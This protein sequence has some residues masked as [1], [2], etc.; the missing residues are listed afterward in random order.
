MPVETR[1]EL[2]DYCLRALGDDV[3]EINVSEAQISDRIDDAVQYWQE[4]HRDGF[5]K[6]YLIHEITSDDIAN[7]YV[8]IGLNVLY[9]TGIVPLTSYGGSVGFFDYEYQLHLHDIFDLSFSGGLSQFVQ[10]KQYLGLI[11]DTIRGKERV[12]YSRW[13]GK[14]YIDVDWD[15]LRVGNHVVVEAYVRVDPDLV[16]NAWNDQWLK[17]YATALI[18]KQWGN[19]LMK[20][21]GVEILGGVTMDGD[22]ISSAAEAAIEK[23]EKEMVS[24][25]SDPIDFFMG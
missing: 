23:L 1:E 18:Q 13:D 15:R 19:N 21:G 8:P 22:K 9:V 6:T 25:H 16:P 24:K 11:Q 2:I 20:F 17:A 7:K 14:L 12:R 10:T 5:V 3:I 4:Y